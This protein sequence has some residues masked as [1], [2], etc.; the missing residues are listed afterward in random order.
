MTRNV[1]QSRRMPANAQECI[2]EAF[3]DTQAKRA[4]SG[5]SGPLAT[6]ADVS[7]GSASPLS[8]PT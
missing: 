8:R 4:T 7:E 5:W 2:Q 3:P 6:I 1:A